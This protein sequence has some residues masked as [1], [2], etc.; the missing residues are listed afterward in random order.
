[1][2]S[3]TNSYFFKAENSTLTVEEIRNKGYIAGESLNGFIEVTF[4]E[5][6]DHWVEKLNKKDITKSHFNEDQ[7]DIWELKQKELENFLMNSLKVGT[8]RLMRCVSS[9]FGGCMD[10][11]P[12]LIAYNLDGT[13]EK[14]K[15]NFRKESKAEQ[16]FLKEYNV[17]GYFDTVC[18]ARDTTDHETEEQKLEVKLLQ[19]E[20]EEQ[21]YKK[22]K[23]SQPDL[24]IARI[25]LFAIE[26]A[27]KGT[28]YYSDGKNEYEN[29]DFMERFI[30]EYYSNQE[31]KEMVNL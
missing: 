5:S 26:T 9:S 27:R 13:R 25:S 7:D 4:N 14:A 16:L 23:D 24:S 22:W 18:F 12:L 10:D 31:I 1:M 20:F 11:C 21:E 29:L 28:S 6:L 8:P 17:S 3:N 2:S 15:D 30:K 19:K